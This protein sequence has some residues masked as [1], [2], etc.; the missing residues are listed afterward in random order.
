MDCE[1]AKYNMQQE[2][3]RVEFIYLPSEILNNNF[4]DK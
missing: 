3:Y 2:I 1:C 4:Y